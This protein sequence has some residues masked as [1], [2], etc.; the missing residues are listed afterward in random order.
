M[1]KGTTEK[2]WDE[3]V[4]VTWSGR[5]FLAHTS[6]DCEAASSHLQQKLQAG[7]HSIHST[8]LC[9]FPCCSFKSQKLHIR[10]PPDPFKRGLVLNISFWGYKKKSFFF[11]CV[12]GLEFTPNSYCGHGCLVWWLL[13]E[14]K[15]FQLSLNRI[16]LASQLIL[17]LPLKQLRALFVPLICK[18]A[19]L[20]TKNTLLK[21]EIFL[22]K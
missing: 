20:K 15:K 21:G 5:L 2:F 8:P 9:A 4:C 18:I 7:S 16:C 3:K 1:P 22:I 19:T 6:Q 12:G 11:L 14:L 17:L 10:D 13:S